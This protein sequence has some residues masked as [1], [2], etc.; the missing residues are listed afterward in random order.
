LSAAACVGLLLAGSADAE[1]V[2]GHQLLDALAIGIEVEDMTTKQFQMLMWANGYVLGFQSGAEWQNERSFCWPDGDTT[3]GDMVDAVKRFLSH[4][5]VYGFGVWDATE[6]LDL[7]A[8]A[9]V[10]AALSI[11]YP[12]EGEDHD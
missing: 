2:D 10:F 12:C 9:I 7:P 5:S 4:G 6:F 1:S 8:G 11:A 3:G